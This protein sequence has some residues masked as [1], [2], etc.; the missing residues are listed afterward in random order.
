MKPAS[1]ERGFSIVELMVAVAIGLVLML[2]VTGVLLRNEGRNRDSLAV[3]D[4]GQSGAYAAYLLD[5]A[6]RSAGTGFGLADDGWFGGSSK[7]VGCRVN[8]KKAG[9]TILPRS[10]AWPAPF[11]GFPQTIRVAPVIIGK[12]QS[13]SGSDVIA[14]MRG[15]AGAGE[16]VIQTQG[17]TL[18]TPLGLINTLG[19]SANQILLL[20]DSGNDCLLLQTGTPAADTVPLTG[21]GDFHTCLLYTSCGEAR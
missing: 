15:N 11:A 21:S 14:V 2:A 18:G 19:M 6:V 8:A 9:A 12:G 4:I 10:A 5:S 7:V 1:R 17:G 13:A 16:A 3:N 20:A